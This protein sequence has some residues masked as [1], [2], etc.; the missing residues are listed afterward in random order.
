MCGDKC[1]QLRYFSWSASDSRRELIPLAFAAATTI[2]PLSMVFGYGTL[3]YGSILLEES[4]AFMGSTEQRVISPKNV[5]VRHP[6]DHLYP[7]RDSEELFHICED[8][9]IS[10]S[11]MILVI[12]DTQSALAH[13]IP[14]RP[15]NEGITLVKLFGGIGIGL[16]A[17]LEVGLMV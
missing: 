1:Y 7:W 2:T 3:T 16:A 14:W 8:I 13:P 4:L 10:L 12:P 9:A 15:P 11:L 6:K 5:L 17:V